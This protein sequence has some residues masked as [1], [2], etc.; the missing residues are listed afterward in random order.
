MCLIAFAWQHHPRWPLVL[1]GN[2]DEFH[3]R[4]ATPAEFQPDAMQVYGGRDLE[5]QG[6]WLQLSARRRLAAVTNVRV[7]G[8]QAASLRSRGALVAGF[9]RAAASAKEWIEAVRPQAG[10]YGHFNLLLWDGAELA[11]AGN[12]PG[13]VQQRVAAGVHGISNGPF[14]APWPKVRRAHAALSQWLSDAPAS[15]EVDLEPLFTALADER[16]AP[17]EQLPDTGVGLALE[18]LLSS[19]FIRGERYG[20]R[21][22]SIVLVGRDHAVFAERR[23]GPNGVALGE[24]VQR[25]DLA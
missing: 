3:A 2:R 5:K 11:L 6:G 25:L 17:D 22:S 14:D 1:I 12:Y 18:R 15:G 13:F 24:S 8:M 19:P 10:E 9:A 4:A 21:C 20:T 7:G 23:F 16:V